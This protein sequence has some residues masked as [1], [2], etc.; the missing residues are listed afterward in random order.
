MN[1]EA[2]NSAT[3]AN[4]RMSPTSHTRTHATRSTTPI[5]IATTSVLINVVFATGR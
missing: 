4:V 1:T 2:N 5:G 3:P